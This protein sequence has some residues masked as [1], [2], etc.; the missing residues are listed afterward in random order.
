[1]LY[2]F[3]KHK[4]HISEKCLLTHMDWSKWSM[5]RAA[6]QFS[7]VICQGLKPS[8]ADAY[9]FD[10]RSLIA[11]GLLL[12]PDYYILRNESDF[13]IVVENCFNHGCQIDT[14]LFFFDTQT[15][16]TRYLFFEMRSLFGWKMFM[17][18]EMFQ[19]NTSIFTILL[20]YKN[21]GSSLL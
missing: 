19:W 14:Y 11:L 6:I 2:N 1:M 12:H 21:S 20:E 7:P 5:N 8:A 10:F 4:S 16:C 3:I 18:E 13:V 15:I 9:Y 17:F